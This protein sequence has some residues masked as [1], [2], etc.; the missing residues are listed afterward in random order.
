MVKGVG[1]GGGEAVINASADIDTR[2]GLSR[3]SE[4]V[5]E[6]FILRHKDMP[7]LSRSLIS[8]RCV[9]Y[10]YLA[11]TMKENKNIAQT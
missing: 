4:K 3:W 7:L 9:T 8:F 10:E 2:P 11:I 1:E 5:A 6:S